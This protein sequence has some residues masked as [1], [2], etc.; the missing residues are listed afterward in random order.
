MDTLAR[1]IHRA[2]LTEA[3]A[4]REHDLDGA[5]AAHAVR[6][7]DTGGVDAGLLAAALTLRESLGRINDLI[8]VSGVPLALPHVLEEGERTAR[9]RSRRRVAEFKLRGGA[10]QT[11][12]ATAGGQGPGHACRR[13]F[14]PPGRPL[15][16]R[17]GAGPLPA[18]QCHHRR[19]GPRQRA[20][21]GS[22]AVQVREFTAA[23]AAHAAQLR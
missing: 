19:L 14:R 17:P 12:C 18:D 15:R 6:A 7:A 11:P 20:V 21:F 10:A 4:A 1:F 5:D 16:H 9:R 22:T 13:P 2:P 3:I 8:H 23:H